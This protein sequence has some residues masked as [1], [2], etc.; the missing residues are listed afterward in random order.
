MRAAAQAGLSQ[1]QIDDV[2][3]HGNVTIKVG[4]SI[5]YPGPAG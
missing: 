2:L 1:Q 3:Q 4:H 5:V